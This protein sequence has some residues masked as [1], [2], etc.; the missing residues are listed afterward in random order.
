MD[1]IG[2]TVKNVIFRKVKSGQLV[3]CSPL[4]FSEAVTNFFSSIHF[5]YLPEN[6]NIIEPED[7]IKARNID[8]YISRKENL[9]SMAILTLIFSK[10]LMMKI[11][12][13]YSGMVA[14]MKSSA[15]MLKP[16]KVMTNVR[17]AREV[18]MK[19]KSDYVVL[20]VI[21]GTMKTLFM[22]NLSRPV[23]LLDYINRLY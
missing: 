19:M 23:I 3:V 1:A 16:V 2:G 12:F 6:K 7:I 15:A 4:A 21:N 20:Y 17:N 14:R 9:V 10:L 13:T 8:Q 22:I 18:T 11:L 5:V